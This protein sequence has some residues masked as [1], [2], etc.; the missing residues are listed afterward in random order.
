MQVQPNLEAEYSKRLK[1]SFCSTI[2]IHFETHND[3]TIGL[4]LKTK[5]NK[6]KC[7]HC[8]Q[9]ST[10]DQDACLVSDP[11]ADRPVVNINKKRLK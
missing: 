6:T 2:F 7:K 10:N 5:I 9:N 4:T 11:V 3:G 8:T 1:T